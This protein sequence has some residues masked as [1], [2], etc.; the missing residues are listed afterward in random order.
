[1]Q[2]RG[3][4]TLTTERLILRRFETTDAEDMFRNWAQSEIVT[5]FLS[6]EPY[7][8]REDAVTYIQSIIDGDTDKTYHWI[9]TLKESGEAIGAI[10]VIALREDIAEAEIGYCLGE[11]YW[12]KGYMTE[13]FR[14]VIRFLFDEVGMNRIEATHDVNNPASGRVMEKCGL[15][16]EGT[17]RQAGHNN[18][19]VCDLVIRAILRGDQTR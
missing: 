3:T 2:H 10:D 1:M 14:A 16:Y 6:W 17:L 15:R 9:I 13:A 12:G 7:K 8:R 4:V 11:L 19:G 5:K 18:Q